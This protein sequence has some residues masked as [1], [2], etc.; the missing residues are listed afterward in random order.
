[1]SSDHKWA[2]GFNN[3]AGL[4]LVSSDVPSF[5]GV[6]FR[7]RSKPLDEGIVR[8]RGDKTAGVYGFQTVIWYV[9]A[10]S[11]QQ[12]LYIR[13]TYT[14][15]GTGLSAKMTIRTL[16]G[17][18]SGVAT[19]ANFSAVLHLPKRAELDDILNAFTGIQLRFVI[20]AAL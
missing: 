5:Q 8:T 14:P 3:A 9:D 19:Y 16:T 18:P 7:V 10:M 4:A 6:V 20:E 17:Y 11:D 12:Y 15:G 2:A 1:M 13:S